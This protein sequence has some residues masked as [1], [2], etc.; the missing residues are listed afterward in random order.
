MRRLPPMVAIN[1]PHFV[2]GVVPGTG[3][4]APIIRYMADWS[5][6]QILN[7]CATKGWQALVLQ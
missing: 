6:E 3:Q 2:A 1:A 4:C 5:T 7:Y